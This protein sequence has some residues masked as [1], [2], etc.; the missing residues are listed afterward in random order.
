MCSDEEAPCIPVHEDNTGARCE[1]SKKTLTKDVIV[2]C[3]YHHC[4]YLC[5][6]LG[7][8][9][10]KLGGENPEPEPEPKL[11]SSAV[12]SSFIDVMKRLYPRDGQG[13]LLKRINFSTLR[14][15]S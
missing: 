13:R 11:S 12:I 2:G 8:A 14:K 7:E 6:D 5:G 1:N 15:V 10:R 4:C 9:W 3:F